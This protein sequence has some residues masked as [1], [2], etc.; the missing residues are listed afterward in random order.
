MLVATVTAAV[1]LIL[2]VYFIRIY[3]GFVFLRESVSRA[4]S[5]ID[6]LLTQRHDE[7]PKLVEACKAY[8]RHERKTLVNVMRARAAVHTAQQ[9]RDVAAVGL[10]ESALRGDLGRLFALAEGYPELRASD[11][12]HRLQQRISQLEEAIADRREL[13]NDSV[14]ILNIRI[15]QFPDLLIARIFRF[16]RAALLEFSEAS[17]AAVDVGELVRDAQGPSLQQ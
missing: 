17:L 9:H 16:T 7:L 4:W 6:V 12:F 15:D 10:A 13:Y 14:N 5:N 1:L 8:M 3:N 11:L 2:V